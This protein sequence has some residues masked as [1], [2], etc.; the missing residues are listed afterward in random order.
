MARKSGNAAEKRKKGTYAGVALI[1]FGVVGA[2]VAYYNDSNSLDI[3]RMH[4][5]ADGA[6]LHL[7]IWTFAGL[8]VIF[9]YQNQ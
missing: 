4:S 5:A 1:A 9:Y 8:G 3:F 2:I 7:M 6:M